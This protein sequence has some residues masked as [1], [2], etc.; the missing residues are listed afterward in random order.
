MI[1][2]RHEL[3][4]LVEIHFEYHIRASVDNVHDRT[5]WVRKITPKPERHKAGEPIITLMLPPIYIDEGRMRK[6]GKMRKSLGIL[7]LCNALRGIQIAELLNVDQATVTRWKHSAQKAPFETAKKFVSA[8]LTVKGFRE[9]DIQEELSISANTL[10]NY[11]ESAE[12]KYAYQAWPNQDDS[13]D[14]ERV[15]YDSPRN[16]DMARKRQFWEVHFR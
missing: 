6:H 10:K 15:H 5:N 1:L 11:T 14:R 8:I 12:W 13:Q 9:K 3:Q 16:R 7:L 4:K 2:R